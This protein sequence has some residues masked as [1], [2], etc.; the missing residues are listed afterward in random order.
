MMPRPIAF[1]LFPSFSLITI[2]IPITGYNEM[3]GERIHHIPWFALLA[4]FGFIISYSYFKGQL[5]RKTGKLENYAELNDSFEW[6]CTVTHL[7]LE[8]RVIVSTPWVYSSSIGSLC[9]I[10][11]L[12]YPP[13]DSKLRECPGFCSALVRK[14]EHDKSWRIFL[15]RKVTWCDLSSVCRVAYSIL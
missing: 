10:S 3:I 13:L 4:F 14:C 8:N 7:L 15:V 6:I 12:I 11:R 9:I 1:P 5:I 2:S